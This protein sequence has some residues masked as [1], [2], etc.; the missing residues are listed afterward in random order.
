MIN[1]QSFKTLTFFQILLLTIIN[2]SAMKN[3]FIFAAVL[4]FFV[5]CSTVQPQQIQ[6]I[7]EDENTT[8]PPYNAE[9]KA[10]FVT[11]DS[12]TVRDTAVTFLF[13]A[14]DSLQINNDFGD[15]YLIWGDKT[16]LK[17]VITQ[18]G[19]VEMVILYN[20]IEEETGYATF[21]IAQKLKKNYESNPRK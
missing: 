14:A 5:S 12:K 4:L 7:E 15:G 21:F 1:F 18:D 2:L 16:G 9:F 19:N 8:P 3:L 10:V 11:N 6:V 17:E 20:D 13:T